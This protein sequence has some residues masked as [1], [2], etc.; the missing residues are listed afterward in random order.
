MDSFK[1][2]INVTVGENIELFFMLMKLV[3]EEMA[4]LLIRNIEKMTPLPEQPRQ[5]TAARVAFN[6]AVMDGLENLS[7][8]KKV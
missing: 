5:R 4:D 7:N 1:F 6:I 3:D 2:D 8:S